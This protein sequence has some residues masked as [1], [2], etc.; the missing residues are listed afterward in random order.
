MTKLRFKVIKKKKAPP[1]HQTSYFFRNT[2][3]LIRKK[4]TQVFA[5]DAL[6]LIITPPLF[7][8]FASLEWWHWYHDMPT[9]SP[10]LL[11]ITALCLSIYCIYK[12]ITSKKRVEK[13]G[14]LFKTINE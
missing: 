8:A 14:G 12:F 5:D 9:P 10:I 4:I 3:R 11:T 6:P 13:Q 2:G 1:P 7:I